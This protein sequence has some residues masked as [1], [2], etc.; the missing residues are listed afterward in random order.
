MNFHVINPIKICIHFKNRLHRR[1]WWS[2][3]ENTRVT[4][5]SVDLKLG[6]TDLNDRTCPWTV[7]LASGLYKART[8]GILLMLIRNSYPMIELMRLSHGW[9]CP[10]TLA[11]HER[12]SLSF[13]RFLW[14]L[15]WRL[16]WQLPGYQ[17]VHM[18]S[19]NRARPRQTDMLW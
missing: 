2:F 15:W 16:P 4:Q 18:C 13:H 10:L 5:G 11:P 3:A 6:L 17:W 7:P 12:S 9:E 1:V 14:H 19:R 8:V